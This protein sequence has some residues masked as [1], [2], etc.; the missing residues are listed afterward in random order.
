[1][2]KMFWMFPNVYKCSSKL[3]VMTLGLGFVAK[4]GALEG[5]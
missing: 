5:K 4:A 3:K 1:M 2:T